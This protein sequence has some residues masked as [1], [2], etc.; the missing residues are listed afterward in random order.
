MARAR[1]ASCNLIHWMARFDKPAIAQ[2]AEHL[3]VDIC[4]HQMVP[5]SIPGGRTM[6]A[7]LQSC[8]HSSHPTLC[9]LVS[10]SVLTFPVALWD[11]C[12]VLPAEAV[13]EDAARQACAPREARTPDLEVNSLTL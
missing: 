10:F 1:I 6:C 8:E 4:S 7:C 13:D 5:G 9:V 3:T 12:G 2:L 11:C